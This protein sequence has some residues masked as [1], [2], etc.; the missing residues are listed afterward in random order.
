VQGRL[1]YLGD[2]SAE[3][4]VVVFGDGRIVVDGW[5]TY[6]WEESRWCVVEV[7]VGWK[8]Q[9]AKKELRVRYVGI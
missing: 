5:D 6:K 1:A 4:D 7:S 3:A 9:N 8:V 2:E